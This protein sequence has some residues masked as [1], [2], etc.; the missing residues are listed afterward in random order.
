MGETFVKIKVF[1]LKNEKE[2][3]VEVLVD[4]GATYT[5]LPEGILKE[6]GVE[7][8]GKV[9]IEFANG[10]VEQRDIGNALV[11][12]EGIRRANPVLFAKEK[13]A[14][15]LGLITLESCGLTVDPVSKKLVPLPKIHH[16]GSKGLTPLANRVFY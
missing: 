12:V 5:I 9:N 10:E 8:I 6:I 15:V 2:Q 13:D 4:T 3:E 1:N 7:K 11:E 14:V 16:Y